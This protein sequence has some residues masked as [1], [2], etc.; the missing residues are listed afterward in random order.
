MGNALGSAPSERPVR[1][2]PLRQGKTEI[3]RFQVQVGDGVEPFTASPG[4]GKPKLI[5]TVG[6][7]AFIFRSLNLLDGFP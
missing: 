5:L 1:F 3:A 2:Q 7:P 4:E 6:H